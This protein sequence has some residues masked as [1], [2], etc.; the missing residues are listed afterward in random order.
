MLI[1]SDFALRLMGINA[2]AGSVF[3]LNSART[4]RRGR[5]FSTGKQSILTCRFSFDRPNARIAIGDRVHIG[6]S[7]LVA[8]ESIVIE[9]D[10]LISWGV[11]IND[12]N[13]HSL[14]VNERIR[15]VTDWHNHTKDWRN[16]V[17]RPIVVKRRS[18]IGFGA[19]VLKGVTIGEGAVVGACSVVTKDVPRYSVVAGNPAVVIRMLVDPESAS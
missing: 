16:V 8:A 12:H 1:K 7:H 17:I 18:W 9:D 4:A 6:K 13:S 10:V 15:D 2:G 14:S 19:T 5:F 11:T 3:G